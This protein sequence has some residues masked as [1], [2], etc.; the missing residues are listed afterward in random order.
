MREDVQKERDALKNFSY[1]F[2]MT[3]G[4][5]HNNCSVNYNLK[6]YLQVL[7]FNMR[8]PDCPIDTDIY[9]KLL[10]DELPTVRQRYPLEFVKNIDICLTYER[11]KQIYSEAVTSCNIQDERFMILKN[12][13][14]EDV[15]Y[16]S[17]KNLGF[18]SHESLGMKTKRDSITFVC[19]KAVR[20]HKVLTTNLDSVK[21]HLNNGDSL[22][23]THFQGV[24]PS[25]IDIVGHRLG[26]VDFVAAVYYGSLYVTPYRSTTSIVESV[27]DPVF[28]IHVDGKDYEGRLVL[29]IKELA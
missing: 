22:L 12:E 11:L 26:G 10:E 27:I 23:H 6:R 18:L 25:A 28:T 13:L 9:E 3:S 14:K 24:G 1:F 5:S 19:E 29:P 16:A 15:D 2:I 21:K 17:I 8:H 20:H 4:L 7:G